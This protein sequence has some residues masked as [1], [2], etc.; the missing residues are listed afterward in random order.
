MKY[1]VIIPVYNS[2]LTIKDCILSLL[3]N[4]FKDYEIIIVN[5]GSTDQSEN[6]IQNLIE[7]TNIKIKYFYTSNSGV[8]SARSF[9]F[10]KSESN[11]VLFLDSDDKVK[12]NFFELIEKYIG[13]NDLLIFNY[14]IISTHKT[15]TNKLNYPLNSYDFSNIIDLYYFEF[16]KTKHGQF[17]WNK[18]YKRNLINSE[19]FLGKSPLEDIYFNLYYYFNAKSVKII[20]E[21]LYSYRFSNQSLSRNFNRNSFIIISH[22]LKIKSQLYSQLSKE[23]YLDSLSWLTLNY[24][25]SIKLYFYKTPNTII[26]NSNFIKNLYLGDSIFRDSIKL[27]IKKNPS[28][29]SILLFLRQFTLLSIIL[30][31]TAKI[32]DLYHGI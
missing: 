32:R 15:F 16:F 31:M 5:D 10:N 17:V 6:I 28:I 4:N 3:S 2:S 12:F 26:K 7:S 1:S 20:D 24:L 30:F 27:Y 13:N 18:V 22:I 29:I 25:N 11:F 8:S 21:V 19:Y 9:G 23:H 14:E